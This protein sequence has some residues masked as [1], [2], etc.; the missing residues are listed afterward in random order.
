MISKRMTRP[1]VRV[2]LT[3]HARPPAGCRAPRAPGLPRRTGRRRRRGRPRAPAR[4]RRRMPAQTA[5]AARRRPASGGVSRP[6][7]R[8]PPRPAPRP[9]QAWPRPARRTARAFPLTTACKS[10]T[11]VSFSARGMQCARTSR[12]TS[13]LFRKCTDSFFGG[14]REVVDCLPHGGTRAARAGDA[15]RDKCVAILAAALTPRDALAPAEAAARLEAALFAT[16][17]DGA[18]PAAAPPAA[19]GAGAGGSGGSANGGAHPARG[20]SGDGAGGSG[21]RAGAADGGGGGGACGPRYKRRARLLWGLLAADSADCLPELRARVLRG[22]RPGLEFPPQM[23]LRAA[24]QQLSGPERFCLLRAARRVAPSWAHRQASWHARH[25]LGML[26]VTELGHHHDPLPSPPPAP[27]RRVGA[28]PKGAARG[29]RDRR[30]RP[31]DRQGGARGRPARHGGRRR[32]RAAL[33]MRGGRPG[34][35]CGRRCARHNF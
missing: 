7:R 16:Y 26:A 5:A 30:Q 33:C 6:R 3:A 31:R 18:S 8:R 20:G 35:A 22:A 9:A 11:P 19:D 34:R 14:V 10:A 28:A 1:R 24:Q 21:G 12:L 25:G 2:R 13:R 29:R 17:G 15:T 23:R 32:R 4:A 27:A